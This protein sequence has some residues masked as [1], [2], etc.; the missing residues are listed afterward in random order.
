MRKLLMAVLAAAGLAF[1]KRQQQ[2]KQD[3]ELWREATKGTVRRH[4]GP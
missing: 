4:E 3:A 1:A 2:A